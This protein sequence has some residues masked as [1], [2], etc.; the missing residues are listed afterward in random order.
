MN[1]CEH[2]KSV[3]CRFIF[4]VPYFRSIYGVKATS[5]PKFMLIINHQNAVV[6]V[7]KKEI[8]MALFTLGKETIVFNGPLVI[9]RGI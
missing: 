4:I 2:L 5:N 8:K 9:V 1:R 3:T 7:V 6:P